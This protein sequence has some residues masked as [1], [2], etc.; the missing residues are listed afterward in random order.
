NNH[1]SFN[2]F[3]F[4]SNYSIK[5]FY[6]NNNKEEEEENNK[7]PNILQLRSKNENELNNKKNKKYLNLTSNQKIKLKFYEKYLLNPLFNYLINSFIGN[8]FILF[9]TILLLF[10]SFWQGIPLIKNNMDY[11]NILPK[12]SKVIK[13]FDIMDYIWN[14]FIQI[15]YIIQKPPNFENIKQFGE[16]K[17]FLLESTSLNQ[18]FNN[19]TSHMSWLFDYYNNKQNEDILNY[20]HNNNNKLINFNNNKFKY[21]NMS[22]FNSFINEFPYNAWKNGINYE[23]NINNNNISSI[24]INKMLIL[25][26]Y[27]NTKGLSGKR[28]LINECRNVAK[29]F[30][31]FKINI[32]DTDLITTDIMN[33]IDIINL[34]I[35]LI[36]FICL[37]I[38][39][40][41]IMKWNFIFS[42]IYITSIISLFSIIFGFS[43]FLF[44]FEINFITIPTIIIILILGIQL[45]IEQYLLRDLINSLFNEIPIKKSLKYS[46]KSIIK[47]FPIWLALTLPLIFFAQY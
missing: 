1:I 20:L 33:I 44:N 21:V 22:K 26:A 28:K 34:N 35:L 47:I 10:L 3:K 36:I 2:F 46:F 40:N 8:C 15:L 43:Q 27:K 18:T 25:F 12:E 6:N 37:I 4:N 13:G 42:I 45:F 14:D 19:S 9:I 5:E 16:F 7:I 39:I 30:P 38:C 23:I 29:H 41:L 31:Q 24:K 11:I 17:E 32:F